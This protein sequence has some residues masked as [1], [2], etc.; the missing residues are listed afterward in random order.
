MSLQPLIEL[1][2][3]FKRFQLE[4]GAELKVLEGVNLSVRDGDVVA[5]LGPSGSGKSTLLRILSGLTPP[6]AGEVFWHGG[7]MAQ[8]APNVAIVFQSFAL[9]PWLTVL[10]YVELGLEAVERRETGA[11]VSRCDPAKAVDAIDPAFKATQPILCRLR[12]SVGPAGCRR[13]FLRIC[14][15][16]DRNTGSFGDSPILRLYRGDSDSPSRREAS[17]HEGNADPFQ[18]CQVHG[19]ESS[20]GQ[21]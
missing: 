21:R 12:R 10:G 1:R 4:S 20:L 16:V 6:S 14:T 19:R 8:A 3:V 5:L 2:S 9:F 17:G 13:G 11:A 15:P 18:F 7:P